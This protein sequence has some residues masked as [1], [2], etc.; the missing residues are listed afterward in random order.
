MGRCSEPSA[1]ESL[2][3]TA[4]LPGTHSQDFDFEG[5]AKFP[6]PK[7]SDEACPCVACMQASVGSDAHHQPGQPHFAALCPCRGYSKVQALALHWK[8]RCVNA[9]LPVALIRKTHGLPQASSAKSII[10]SWHSLPASG[11][12]CCNSGSQIAIKCSSVVWSC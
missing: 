6:T 8:S 9:Y 3:R 4:K 5:Q 11:C 7:C 2:T 12:S 1:R 10:P